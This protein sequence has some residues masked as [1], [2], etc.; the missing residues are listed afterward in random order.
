MVIVM[1]I[2]ETTYLTLFTY[3]VKIIYNLDLELMW[4]RVDH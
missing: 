2:I 3:M 4:F 1:V